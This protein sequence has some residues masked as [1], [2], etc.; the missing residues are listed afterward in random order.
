V[1]GKRQR[2]LQ[3]LQELTTMYL[4]VKLLLG[5]LFA[6]IAAGNVV[7]SNDMRVD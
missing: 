2:V 5:K 6:K 3:V 7:F 1:W 4:Q